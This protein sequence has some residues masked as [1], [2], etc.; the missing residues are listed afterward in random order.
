M[1]AA[2]APSEE[3]TREEERALSASVVR[4]DRSALDHFHGIYST[5]LYRFVYYRV[6]GSQSDTDEVVQETFLAALEGL[7]RFR[8]RS[9]LFTWLCG[10]AKNRIARLR[11]SQSRERLAQVIE[12]ADPA[13]ESMLARLDCEE[14]PDEVLERE[15]TQDLVCAT[16]AS[17]PPG[18]QSVL[19]DKY[20][21]SI[22]VNEMAW[23]RSSTSKSVE[24]T[25]TRARIAFR[26]A[27]QLLSRGLQMSAGPAQQQQA[28]IGSRSGEEPRH[29]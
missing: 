7:H 20:V 17:L 23:R 18:Y 21:D 11:R 6:G 10:I 5:P 16:M 26:K 24:S 9:A 15:E 8:G 19:V 4:G 25:L 28:A 3:L 14:L 29:A 13:I 12:G 27:F 2:E 1:R 22:S